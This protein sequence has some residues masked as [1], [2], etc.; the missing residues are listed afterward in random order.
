M[1]H[2]NHMLRWLHLVSWLWGGLGCVEFGGWRVLGLLHGD[3]VGGDRTSERWSCRKFGPGEY[4]AK[5]S[6]LL[7]FRCKCVHDVHLSQITS[8]EMV[9][10]LARRY[11]CSFA[12]EQWFSPL[13]SAD[14]CTYV[15][16]SILL[17]IS[18]G[19]S[20][21][22]FFLMFLVKSIAWLM[23][24]LNMLCLLCWVG[25]PFLLKGDSFL[26]CRC[27]D[28]TQKEGSNFEL[29][30]KAHRQRQSGSCSSH[31]LQGQAK[32]RSHQTQ[33]S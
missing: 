1:S 13:I 32:V 4:V 20:K 17:F 28:I 24:V 8:L 18:F 31:A 15:R 25:A 10:V 6:L 29:W 3:L 7:L 27:V 33:N 2:L 21:F 26:H 22:S 19:T 12:I 9:E 16:M 23:L 30:L 11:A 14:V 5:G